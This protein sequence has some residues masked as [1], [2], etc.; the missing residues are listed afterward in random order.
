M[1]GGEG[2]GRADHQVVL[3]HRGVLVDLFRRVHTP[4]K[5]CCR[6]AVLRG[7]GGGAEEAEEEEAEEG[8]EGTWK[9]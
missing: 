8:R 7:G 3:V 2:G 9:V 1:P 6:A 5:R 4:V